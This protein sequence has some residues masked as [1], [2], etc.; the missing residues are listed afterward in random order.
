MSQSVK[1]HGYQIVT[2][3][4]G[5]PLDTMTALITL[6][7]AVAESHHSYDMVY[8]IPSHAWVSDNG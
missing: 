7:N 8:M 6:G 2:T 5:G 4:A 1:V 3:A